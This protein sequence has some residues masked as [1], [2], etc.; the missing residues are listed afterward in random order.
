MKKLAIFLSL[1]FIILVAGC[2]DAFQPGKILETKF[3]SAQLISLAEENN[4]PVEMIKD[5]LE[6]AKTD[7][8]KYLKL[9]KLYLGAFL[10]KQEVP[11]TAKVLALNISAELQ[12]IGPIKPNALENYEA[13]RGKLY[14]INH[15][16]VTMNDKSGTNLPIIP[17]TQEFFEKLKL[18]EALDYAP[19]INPYNSLYESSL[20]IYPSSEDKYYKRF[21][22]DM[23]ILGAEIAVIE[24]DLGYKVAFKSTWNVAQD[25]KLYNIR[26]FTGNKG[27]GLTLSMIHWKFRDKFNENWDKLIELLRKESLM[28]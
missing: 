23:A 15:F 19:I 13:F 2:L 1:L 24:A 11:E 26:E 27:Y 9:S 4:V 12:K 22:R 25:L 7:S 14:Q 17:D 10:D 5:V 3:D 6:N 16:I 28:D 8:V 20:N 21:Y 18:K